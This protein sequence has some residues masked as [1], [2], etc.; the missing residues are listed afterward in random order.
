MDY[1]SKCK[2]AFF[3]FNFR[4][5]TLIRSGG[6]FCNQAKFKFSFPYFDICEIA[7]P[8]VF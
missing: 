4:V 5:I 7:Y 1:S 8:A 6:L 3:I 2:L